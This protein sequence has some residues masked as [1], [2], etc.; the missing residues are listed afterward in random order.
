MN[1]DLLFNA[2]GEAGLLSS[3]NFIKKLVGI[4]LDT[5]NGAIS[6]EFAD[7]N[8][9]ELNI[10]VEEEYFRHLEMIPLM[11]VGAV[12]SGKIAQAYQVPLM[13]QDDPYR[14]D[15]FK[16]VRVPKKPLEAFHY[17]VKTCVLGQPVHRD[18]AG[19][20]STAGCILG[21]ALPS[22]LEFAP[23]L[24]R[25]HTMEVAPTASPTMAPP[26]M[27]LGGSGG[28]SG[29]STYRTNYTQPPQSDDEE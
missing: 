26:G 19:D 14:A 11:H 3:E 6:L 27:G 29:R 2:R 17:F 18:D 13:L 21:D 1:I 15:A 23:H 7:M 24:A 8:H 25:R 16:N 10:P 12:K 4:V 28:S 22:S 9:M 20:E 5:Q